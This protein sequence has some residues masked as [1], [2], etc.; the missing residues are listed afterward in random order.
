MH[1]DA[2]MPLEIAMDTTTAAPVMP[3]PVDYRT[4]PS[5]YRHW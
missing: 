1:Y 5:Q 3:P 4:D 2:S